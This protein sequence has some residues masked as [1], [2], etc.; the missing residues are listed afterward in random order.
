MYQEGAQVLGNCAAHFGDE[1]PIRFDFLDTFN[2]GNL[3]IQVHPKPEY[4]RQHF[5]ESFTQDETYYIMDCRPGAQVYLGFQAGI[6]PQRLRGEQLLI[7]VLEEP[8][9]A[10]HLFSCVCETMIQGLR[11]LHERQQI[12]V[13]APGLGL[14]LAW[15]PEDPAG[16]GRRA[17]G[18]AAG[19][20]CLRSAGGTG[21]RTFAVVMNSTSDRS[22]GTSR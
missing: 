2:G 8:G 4:I 1:F 19:A 16:P 17:R 3:S 10:Q 21:S 22:N 14:R 18:T 7:D 12:Q 13:E 5:G 9:K 15:R 20:G 6:D 11:R